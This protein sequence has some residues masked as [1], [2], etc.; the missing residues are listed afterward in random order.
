MS[1][2]PRK[3]TLGPTCAL[4]AAGLALMA[5]IGFAR[6]EDVSK[7]QIIKALTPANSPRL[8]RGLAATPAD[9]AA[10]A[11]KAEQERFLSTV[12]NR[13][14]RSLT[15]SER[16]TIATIAEEKPRID[17]EINFDYNSAQLSAEARPTASALGDALSSPQLQDGIFILAGHTDAK[18][19]IPF[20]QDLSERRADAIK[21]FLVENH[22]IEP[23]RLVTVGYGKS[24]LKNA[25]DPF[26]GE[27][28]RVQIVNMA[29][30]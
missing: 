25:E 9:P 24:K 8:T 22:D 4:F 19:G 17:L 15:A 11:R 12:R 29:D 5:S 6:A 1:S 28:R 26:G 21:R 30:Q 27:N 2:H 14:T 7:D 16:D 18:G 10:T 13:V 3:Q 20:N 23:S